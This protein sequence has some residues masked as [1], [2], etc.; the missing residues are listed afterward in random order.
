MKNGGEGE[1]TEDERQR[2]KQ[3]VY[4]LVYGVGARTLGDQLKVYNRSCKLT[5]NFVFYIIL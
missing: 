5:Y 3:V 2:A 4:G 1:V